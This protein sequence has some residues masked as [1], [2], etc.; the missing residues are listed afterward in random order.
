VPDDPFGNACEYLI[1]TFASEAGKSSGEFYTLTSAF[2]AT[3]GKFKSENRTALQRC[4]SEAAANPLGKLFKERHDFLRCA[5][6]G[7]VETD[8]SMGVLKVLHGLY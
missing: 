2:V 7:D 8:S 5:V 1:R 3:V 4:F 6:A